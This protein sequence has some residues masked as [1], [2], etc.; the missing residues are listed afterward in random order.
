M[1]KPTKENKDV[2]DWQEL[3]TLYDQFTSAISSLWKFVRTSY[4]LPS[5]RFGSGT[6]QTPLSSF[7]AAPLPYSIDALKRL[8]YLTG[9]RSSVWNHL[10][11]EPLPTP[12]DI[13]QQYRPYAF[14]PLNWLPPFDKHGQIADGRHLFTFDGGHLTFPGTCQYVLAQDMVDGNFSIIVRLAAG[15]LAS[16]TLLDRKDELELSV[17]GATKLNGV[18]NNLPIHRETGIHAWRGYHTV[19]LLSSSGVR[20]QCQ[21][22]L[23]L[24]GIIVSGF[25]HGRLGGLL[26]NGNAEPGDDVQ[27]PTTGEITKDTAAFGTAYATDKSC[28][29]VAAEDHKHHNSAPE[30]QKHFGGGNQLAA[31]ALFVPVAQHREACEHAVGAEKTAAARLDAACNIAAAYVAACRHQNIPISL[32]DECIRCEA[33]VE[34]ADG[35]R[36]VRCQ[37]IMFLSSFFIKMG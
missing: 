15:R 21:L 11:N 3:R 23:R 37:N 30:C 7:F 17:D 9:F 16:I 27:V 20:I 24:C 14:N 32:A 36:M 12:N 8:P 25:Y 18:A 2:N 29:A 28:T 33:D 31:C 35:K 6:A 19:S 34:I 4:G 13:F 10:R 5:D 22:D 26:G 1:K